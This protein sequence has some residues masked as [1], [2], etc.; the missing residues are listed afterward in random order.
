MHTPLRR[1]FLIPLLLIL[2]WLVVDVAL[3][4]SLTKKL[5]R[6]LSRARTLVSDL[7]FDFKKTIGRVEVQS[8]EVLKTISFGFGSGMPIPEMAFTGSTFRDTIV[9][10]TVLVVLARVDGELLHVGFGFR[11][12]DCFISANH[13]VREALTRSTDLFVCPFHKVGSHSE[14]NSQK[15]TRLEGGGR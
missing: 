14:I 13:V 4:W 11:V 2:F 8:Q 7:F 3:L 12:K 6:L 15:L 1:G 10:N 5:Y 9:G